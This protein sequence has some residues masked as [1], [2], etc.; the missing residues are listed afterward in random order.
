MSVLAVF[1]GGAL[2]AALRY[3]LSGVSG[4]VPWGI[5]IANV[6]GSAGLGACLALGGAIPLLLGAGFFGGLSTWS[7]LA[8]DVWSAAEAHGYAM[9]AANLGANLLLGALAYFSAGALV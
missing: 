9:A 7:T 4:R 3:A 5:L 6:A 1:L 8:W 2:G